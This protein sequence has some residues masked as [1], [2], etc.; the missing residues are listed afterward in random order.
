MTLTSPRTC[1]ECNKPLRA[2]MRSVS[3]F[4]GTPCRIAWRNRRT[5][6][7]AELYDC[8]MALR[9]DREAA[10][11]EGLWALMCRMAQSWNDEDKAANRQTYFPPRETVQRNV[12]YKATVV[13]GRKR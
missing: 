8:F 7:G 9:Y 13:V 12:R 2:T 11:D 6:R 4:C 3:E 1:R 5:S 10:R